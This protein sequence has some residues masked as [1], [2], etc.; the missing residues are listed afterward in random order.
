MYG[1]TRL[2]I[3]VA[4]SEVGFPVYKPKPTPPNVP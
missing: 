4:V 3:G 1:I 2:N